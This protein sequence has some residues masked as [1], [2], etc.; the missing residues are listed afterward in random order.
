MCTS[1]FLNLDLF[2]LHLEERNSC[3]CNFAFSATLSDI[4]FV[5]NSLST[6]AENCKAQ[7]LGSEDIT[8]GDKDLE[9]LTMA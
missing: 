7:T 8:I 9:F 1:K 4:H 5:A 3:I 6:K 2:S